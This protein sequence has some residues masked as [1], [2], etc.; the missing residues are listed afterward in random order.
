MRVDLITRMGREEGTKTGMYRG[1]QRVEML[2]L[3]NMA[4]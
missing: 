2:N 4:C 1:D 3:L